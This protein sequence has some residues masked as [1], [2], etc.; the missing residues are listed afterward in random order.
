MVI[1]SG[2]VSNDAVEQGGIG[3]AAQMDPS[4]QV[5]VASGDRDGL[6]TRPPGLLGL[7]VEAAMRL[8]LA[9][10]AVQDTGLRVP[11]G[12]ADGDLLAAVV[13]V[14]VAV[15]GERSVAQLDDRA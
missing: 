6:E 9:A 8:H 13:D 1:S 15:P 12:R 11:A 14:P 5:G 3:V 10:T 7:E 4:A 2:V